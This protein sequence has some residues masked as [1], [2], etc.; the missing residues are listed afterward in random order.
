MKASIIKES[1]E[2]DSLWSR[3][4]NLTISSPI[5]EGNDALD[6]EVH[7]LKLSLFKQKKANDLFSQLFKIKKQI[8]DVNI[9]R[10]TC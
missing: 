7:L 10:W 6:N 1:D 2:L 9:H 8:I 4:Q 3:I 5:K